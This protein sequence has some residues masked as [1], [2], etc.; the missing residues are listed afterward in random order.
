MITQKHEEMQQGEH[1]S[2]PVEEKHTT[3]SREERSLQAL[4]SLRR[5]VAVLLSILGIAMPLVA[6]SMVSWPWG[7]GDVFDSEWVFNTVV[8]SMAVFV[9]IGAFLLSWVYRA[10]W[11]ALLAPLAWVVGEFL[12]AVVRPLVEGGWPALQAQQH[13]WDAQGV[14]IPMA[15]VPLLLC[16]GFGATGVIALDAM[17]RRRASRR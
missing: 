17:V 2:S 8:L 15:L 11:V 7:V 1:I 3:T 10:W 6:G 12:G 13:F 9:A 14:V 16:A 5:W 4:P